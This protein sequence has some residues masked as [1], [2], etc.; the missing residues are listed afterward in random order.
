MSAETNPLIKATS[1]VLRDIAKQTNT[2]ATGLQNVAPPQD[3]GP[4][5]SVLYLSEIS[6]QLEEYAR[7]I[8]NLSS[9]LSSS[10]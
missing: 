4:A 7:T 8:E 10:N 6:Q 9:G 1:T 5:K 2:L 3:S